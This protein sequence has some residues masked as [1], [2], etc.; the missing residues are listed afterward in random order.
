MLSVPQRMRSGPVQQL[1]QHVGRGIEIASEVEPGAAELGVHVVRT[2]PG[3]V[4]AGE[5][6]VDAA[7]LV[8]RDLRQVRAF[9]RVRFQPEWYTTIVASGC[10]AAPAP[11]R[12][13]TRPP[14]RRSPCARDDR[15]AGRDGLRVTR[16]SSRRYAVGVG[17]GLPRRDRISRGVEAIPSSA[18]CSGRWPGRRAPA[19]AGADPSPPREA[20]GSCCIT[21]SASG[22]SRPANGSRRAHRRASRSAEDEVE[23]RVLRGLQFGSAAPRRPPAGSS[24]RSCRNA[25]R[26]EEVELH[27]HHEVGAIEHARCGGG[28]DRRRRARRRRSATSKLPPE[29]RPPFAARSSLLRAQRRE[30]RRRR[31][32]RQELTPGHRASADELPIA[33]RARGPLRPPLVTAGSVVLVTRS[34]GPGRAGASTSLPLPRRWNRP[35]AGG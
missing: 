14:P 6:S 9:R 31:R 7:L 32:G 12:R 2:D 16:S 4:Q 28:V 11:R 21:S 22:E 19:A 8:G 15:D 26:I 3:G 10:A 33:S 34:L 20:L 13:A 17:V 24:D 23:E 25:G 1:A 27:V 18:A 5:Q 35:Q 30:D 29:L